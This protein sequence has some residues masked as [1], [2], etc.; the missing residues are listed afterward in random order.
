[1]RQVAHPGGD[2]RPAAHQVLQQVDVVEGVLDRD[3]GA[4]FAVR[5]PRI[6]LVII[7]GAEPLHLDVHAEDL[8]EAPALDRLLDVAH[9]LAHPALDEDAELDARLAAGFDHLIGLRERHR[10]GLLAQHVLAR[11]RR[12]QHELGVQVVRG[13]DVDDLD[14]GIG[15]HPVEIGIDLGVGR[16]GLGEL[17]GVFLTHVADR[18]HLALGGF[19]ERVGVDAGD[20]AGAEDTES[21]L[22]HEKPPRLT[23]AE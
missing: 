15:Q 13:N 21:N 22:I 16:V 14:R 7:G 10:R 9:R 17:P 5:A 8:A 3:P 4:A 11:R 6:H 12:L 2:H 23:G 18:D 1:M 19:A 20:H